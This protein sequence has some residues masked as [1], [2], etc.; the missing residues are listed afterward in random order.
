MSK[1]GVFGESYGMCFCSEK[2]NSVAVG[3]YFISVQRKKTFCGTECQTISISLPKPGLD[4]VVE[5]Y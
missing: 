4:L 3:H 2:E 5:Y 1:P